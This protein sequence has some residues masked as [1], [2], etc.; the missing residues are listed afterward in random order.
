L[1][2]P[3]RS[4][5]LV[6]SLSC[7]AFVEVVSNSPSSSPSEASPPGEEKGSPVAILPIRAVKLYNSRSNGSRRHRP[8]RESRHMG[9]HRCWSSRHPSLSKPQLIEI[10]DC[11]L[12]DHSINLPSNAP[13]SRQI[14]RPNT[15]AHLSR[16]LHHLPPPWP[17]FLRLQNFA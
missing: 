2:V 6:I 4:Q 14:P 7:I 3:D 11:S 16:P 12:L 9:P 1:L 13:P 8:P 5:F 10:Q 15:M 17:H